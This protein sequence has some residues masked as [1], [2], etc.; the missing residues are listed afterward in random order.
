MFCV[1]AHLCFVLR[2]N[3]YTEQAGCM[4]VDYACYHIYVMQC[5]KDNSTPLS[6]VISLSFG[7]QCHDK[8]S[9]RVEDCKI[10]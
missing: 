8:K 5:T 2:I 3:V 6:F 7:A 4:G 9:K 10:K 1:K